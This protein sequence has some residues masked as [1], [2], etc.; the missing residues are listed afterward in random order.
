MS[1]GFEEARE[2]AETAFAR[3]FVGTELI[4]TSLW[5]FSYGWVFFASCRDYVDKGNVDY[6]GFDGLGSFLITKSGETVFLP[7]ARP[8]VFW[9]RRWEVANNQHSDLAS[10]PE[11]RHLAAR[12]LHSLLA[13]ALFRSQADEILIEIVKN[14]EAIEDDFCF[15]YRKENQEW[16]RLEEQH[17]FTALMFE[18][19]KDI[20]NVEYRRIIAIDRVQNGEFDI[21][22]SGS[23]E[24]FKN[25]TAT[26][27]IQSRFEPIENGTRATL[28][29]KLKSVQKERY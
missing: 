2:M 7:S 19:L 28:F 24:A 25:C 22:F 17:L 8:P 20:F 18:H 27:A 1:I 21:E 9:L 5:A 13:E 12:E 11:A 26:F 6:A 10:R 15:S 14:V 4:I 29:A 16:T 3:L 23:S